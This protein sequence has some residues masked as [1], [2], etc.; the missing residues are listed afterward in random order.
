MRL[1]GNSALVLALGLLVMEGATVMQPAQAELLLAQ[2]TDASQLSD[3]SP[4]ADY[5]TA[6]ENLINEYGV[7]V[8]YPD[9]TF[10][11][12]APLTRGDFA[13]IL[14]GTLENLTNEGWVSPTASAIVPASVN[15]PSDV[16][17]A[18]PYFDAITI[19]SG[20]YNIN[21]TST[22]G[23]FN[24]SQVMTGTEAAMYLNQALGSSVT[25]EDQELSRGEFVMLM[26]QAL[27][28]ANASL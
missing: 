7:N 16:S 5:Y 26:Q 4:T 27:D 1:F 2:V 9:G 12:E 14:N 24:G 3:V 19:L 11:G 15:P 28:E 23:T 22:E 21:L 17:P 20:R 25:G 13:Y 8:A 6:L 18:D 10:R